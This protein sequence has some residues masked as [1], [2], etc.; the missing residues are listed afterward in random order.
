MKFVPNYTLNIIEDTAFAQRMDEIH[1]RLA[2][3][4][5]S[6]DL[7]VRDGVRLFYEYFLAEGAQHSVVLLHGMSEFTCKHYELA[8]YLLEQ[9]YNVFM[10]DQRGHGRSQRLTE[11][12]DLI[13]VDR[14]SDFVEDLQEFVEKIVL[15]V[16]D[17]PLYLYGHSM[18]GAVALF[19]L[20][21]HPGLFQKAVISSPLF[22]PRVPVPTPLA[23]ISAWKDQLLR[24]PKSQLSHT[25]Q[26]IAKIPEAWQNDPACSRNKYMMQLRIDHKDYQTTPMSAGFALRALYLTPALLRIA[27][28]IT[29]PHLLISGTEDTVVKTRPHRRF[30]KR[31]PMCDFVSIPGGKHAM[32]CE[33]AESAAVHTHLV[34]DYWKEAQP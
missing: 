4:R 34:L 10:Y 13:H 15:P 27:K 21:A 33:D 2:Q 12:M 29:T 22:V 24:G 26:F 5:V 7:V 17:T 1:V 8:Y 6:G 3:I 14:F 32:M 23:A 19:H 18:G 30:G 31:A 16:A 11:R 28:K 20:A 9:G 25:R